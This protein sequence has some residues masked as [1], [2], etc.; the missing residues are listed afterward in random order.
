MGDDLVFACI[1]VKGD[2]RVKPELSY[3]EKDYS[4]SPLAYDALS[5]FYDVKG[6]IND[7]KL[8]CKW[9]IRYDFLVN[10]RHYN[11]LNDYYY[12]LLAKG[13]LNENTGN[14]QI[15]NV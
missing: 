14:I 15:L 3:N 6:G 10:N 2:S 13:D 7:G 12:I 11:L 4:N 9:E 8:T 5:F 1:K